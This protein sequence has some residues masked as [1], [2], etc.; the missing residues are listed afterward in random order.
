MEE[1]AEQLKNLKERFG[2]ISAQFDR[3]KIRTEIRELEVEINKPGFWN[4]SE[5]AQK[6]SRQLSGKQK[7]LLSLEDLESRI[8]NAQEMIGEPEMLEDLQKETEIISELLE[9]LEL[10]LFLSG[11]HDESEAILAVHSGT[12]GTEAMDWAAMLA[13]MYQR[14][15]EKQ[16]WTFEISDESP[17]EEAGIKTMTMIVHADFAYGLLKNESGTHRLVRQ[18]PFNADKLRQTSFALVEVL[19]VIENDVEV[20]INPDEIEFEAYRSGGAGGQNVNKVNTAVRLK[21][22]PTGIVVTAQTERSQLQNRENAMRLLKA[23][24]WLLKQ[25]EEKKEI[26]GL[27]GDTRQASWGTQIRSYVLHPYHMVKDLRT[28]VETSNTD[29]VLD[30]DL[31]DFIEAEVRLQPK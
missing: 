13:R 19:P 4:D 7:L 12:G 24:I 28:N 2:K 27:R 16:G 31:Q 18:S 29:A 9:E 26:E 22:T 23:K 17:G 25:A 15:F 14:Y 21:H 1:I 10:K 20:E 5:E 3:D 30:G 8:Q 6:V 11:P